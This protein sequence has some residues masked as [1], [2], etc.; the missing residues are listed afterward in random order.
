[1]E[2]QAFLDSTQTLIHSNPWMA[3][4][5]VFIGGALTAANPCVLAMI[6]LM[7]GF[8]GGNEGIQGWRK[9]FG[10]SLIFVIGLAITFTIMGAIAV[11]VGR[12]F[13]DV[14]T[15]WPWIIAIVC[16]VMAAHLWEL[17]TFAVPESLTRYRPRHSGVIGA[18]ALG[19]LFGIVSAPCAAPILVVVL[20]FIASKANLPYGLALL[21]TY[22]IGHC[23]LIV[24]AG[25]SMGVAKHLLESPNFSKA[26]YYTKRIAGLM[27]AVVGVYILLQSNR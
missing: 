9:S 10:Y 21:W 13:G 4:V 22:A 25:T 27:I 5:A 20:T 8:V 16:I 1:M 7:I 17:W 11:V 26:N 12:L 18:F 6:P 14:G 15:F 19:M 2:L 24:V 3:F 23:L